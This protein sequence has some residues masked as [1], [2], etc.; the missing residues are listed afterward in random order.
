MQQHQ[1][2]FFL[3]K[4]GWTNSTQ[5]LIVSYV[6]CVCMAD[7]RAQGSGHVHV[8]L[9]PVPQL[10]RYKCRRLR[11]ALSDAIRGTWPKRYRHRFGVSRLSS[12]LMVSTFRICI[13]FIDGKKTSSGGRRHQVVFASLAW[14]DVLQRRRAVAL[15]VASHRYDGFLPGLRPARTCSSPWALRQFLHG[16]E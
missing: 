3:E 2:F 12:L 5:P 8:S 7:H 1:R 6:P 9:R 14:V 16:P 15:C 13:C 11:W 4:Q 10:G